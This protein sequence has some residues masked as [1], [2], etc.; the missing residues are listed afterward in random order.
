[1]ATSSSTSSGIA[2]Q[3]ERLIAERF[4]FQKNQ[5]AF[6]L[7]TLEPFVTKLKQFDQ[8]KSEEKAKRRE[9]YFAKLSAQKATV[10]CRNPGCRNDNP[11][12]FQYD[13]KF[14][15]LTCT[16]C[17][18]VAAERLMEDKEWVRSFDDDEADPS[19]H[20]RPGDD[21]L[22]TSANLAT[23]IDAGGGS[24]HSARQMQ[25]IQRKA[26]MDYKRDVNSKERR[27][28]ESYKDEEKRRTFTVMEDI[29]EAIQLHESVLIRA[30][31][32]FAEYRDA[33]EQLNNK[34]EVVAAC[35]LI[36]F[37]EK[38]AM[39]APVVK[40][41]TSANKQTNS[42]EEYQ[43]FKCKYCGDEFT[44][45]R[46]KIYHQKECDKRPEAGSTAQNNNTAS[47][48]K[49]GSSGEEPRAEHESKRMRMG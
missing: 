39:D 3:M 40:G 28:R 18:T 24:R 8:E 19:F 12:F 35:M 37:R 29:A 33:T 13:P 31:R 7:S 36:S 25:E 22:S 42:E 17:G 34:W 32:M 38:M 20:G 43:I 46:D 21:N 27:T 23:S 30:K 1:M 14:A 44:L 45:K 26:E 47:N 10:V 15:Q 5:T 6:E 9:A 48:N 11:E 4:G 41:D 16:R 2:N 49:Q